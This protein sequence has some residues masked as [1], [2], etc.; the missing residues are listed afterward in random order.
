MYLKPDTEKRS[1]GSVLVWRNGAILAF[2]HSWLDNR[3][4]GGPRGMRQ[5]CYRLKH[6]WRPPTQTLQFAHQFRQLCR[7]DSAARMT[8]QSRSVVDPKSRE[9]DII[10][11]V[12]VMVQVGCCRDWVPGGPVDEEL[13]VVDAVTVVVP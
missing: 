1:G 8:A 7:H 10:R 5:W 6:V 12:A 9:F 3:M 4:V 11:P 13:V 2:S